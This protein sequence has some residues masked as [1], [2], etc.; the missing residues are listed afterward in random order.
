MLFM[1]EK[2]VSNS[3]NAFSLKPKSIIKC[4]IDKNIIENI[5]LKNSNGININKS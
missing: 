4:E 5:I 3:V 1:F 2:Y